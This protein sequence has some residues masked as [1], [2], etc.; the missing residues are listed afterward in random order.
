MN[1]PTPPRTFT[2]GVDCT[3]AVFGDP[4]S[5]RRSAA[6]CATLD[7]R[8]RRLRQPSDTTPPSQPSGLAVSST[9]PTGVSLTWAAS[10]DNV[11]VAGYAVYVNGSSVSTVTQLGASVSGLT[12]ATTYSFEVDAYDAA[13]NHSSR[14][15]LSAA[16]A[17]CS[18]PSP[19]PPPPDTTPPSKPTLSLGP[20]TQTTLA[21]DWQAA[22]DNVGVDHYNVWL[23]HSGSSD[24]AKIAQVSAA[25]LSYVYQGLTCG[26]AYTLG[27]EAV[28]A[29]GNK[30]LIG[31]A[32]YGP[33]ST[34][35]CS[36]PTPPPHSTCGRHEPAHAACEPRHL[37]RNEDERVSRLDR[38]FRQR[39]RLGLRDVREQRG[40]ADELPSPGR[41]F[42]TSPAARRTPSRST[43]TTPRATT[44]RAHL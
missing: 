41:P 1:G 26:T 7:R 44:H 34:L 5:A 28:D 42:P 23:G 22:T 4:S 8:R 25:Q 20:Q 39:R 24:F 38:L 13:G 37:E 36:A 2:D 10:S 31:D 21:L 32:T 30:S 29:A 18:A 14:A 19:P 17:S 15:A 12:C 27:L 33:V 6:R 40:G 9:S 3:N 43:P 16:S 11:G 35:A